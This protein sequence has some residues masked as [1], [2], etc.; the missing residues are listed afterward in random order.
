MSLRIRQGDF[1]QPV[2]RYYHRQ[3][4]RNGSLIT[5][6]ILLRMPLLHHAAGHDPRSSTIVSPPVAQIPSGMTSCAIS[7]G[8]R[9]S[10]LS[11]RT[12]ASSCAAPHRKMPPLCSRRSGLPYRR[13]PARSP[14]PTHCRNGWPG[15]HHAADARSVVPRRAEFPEPAC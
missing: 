1:P 13:G 14:P 3:L 11:S 7:I 6:P 2:K 8:S 4:A 9:K 15:R 10:P 12:S 5:Q